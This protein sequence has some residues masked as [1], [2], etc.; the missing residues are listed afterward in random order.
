MWEQHDLYVDNNKGNGLKA[1]L[2]NALHGRTRPFTDEIIKKLYQ[3]IAAEEHSDP[4]L[5]QLESIRD[6]AQQPEGSI[7]AKPE[8]STLTKPEGPIF[9]SAP[10]TRTA[11][12][13]RQLVFP[14][15]KKQPADCMRRDCL[16][17]E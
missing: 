7:L 12:I 11:D 4:A 13:Q 16:R 10:A 14:D 17:W 9:A 3:K 8:G 1:Y 6:D 5:L 15:V 2:L